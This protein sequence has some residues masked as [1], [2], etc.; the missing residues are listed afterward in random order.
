MFTGWRCDRPR[1]FWEFYRNGIVKWTIQANSP[2]QAIWIASMT[3][4]GPH[5]DELMP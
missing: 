3:G 5:V 1:M 4:T 2:W